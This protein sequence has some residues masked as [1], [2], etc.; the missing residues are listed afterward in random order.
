MFNIFIQEFKSYTSCHSNNECIQKK[1]SNKLNGIPT[2]R[3]IRAG[4]NQ[5]VCE[6]HGWCPVEKDE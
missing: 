4:F 5:S 6:I 1:G 2:G 3:C